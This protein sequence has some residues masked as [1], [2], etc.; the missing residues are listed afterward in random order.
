[1]G[2]GVGVADVGV[3]GVVACVVAGTG[4]AAGDDVAVGDT[5]GPAGGVAGA[6]EPPAV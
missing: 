6:T 2:F 4:A 1:L 5:G 3:V